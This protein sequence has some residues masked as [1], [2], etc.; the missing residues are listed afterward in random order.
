VLVAEDTVDTFHGWDRSEPNWIET[1]WFGAWIPE[2]ATTV[3]IYQWFRPV[4]GIYG[5]G[6]FVW[7]AEAYLPWDI[8]VFRYDVNRPLTAS[9]DLRD[10]SLDNGTTLKSV[11][12]GQVYEV[13]FKRGDVDIE[14]RF[15]ANSP[16]DILGARGMAEFFNGHI[17]QSGRYTGSLKLGGEEHPIDCFGIRDRSWGPRLITDDIRLNYCHGQSADFAFV[18]YSRPDGDGETVFRGHLVMDGKRTALAGGR[19]VS[20]FKNAVLQ[21]IDI[22]LTDADG[23]RVAGRGVPLNRMVYES[24][25]GLLNWLYLV[26][27]RIGATVVYGEEQDVWSLPLWHGRPRNRRG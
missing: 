22:E 12:E 23:R 16:P 26:E 11:V 10:L 15:E 7:N 6:C 1:F 3:Y 4:I 25:P 8:P 13:G 18:S 24:Y 19:R 14:M 20:H 21:C 9:A 2:I 5:G 17:D 27:W